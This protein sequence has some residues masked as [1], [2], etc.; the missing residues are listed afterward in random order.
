MVVVKPGAADVELDATT[1]TGEDATGLSGWS[2]KNYFYW[3]NSGTWTNESGS[4][5]ALRIIVNG[6][7]QVAADTTPPALDSAETSVD[8]TSIDLVFDEDLNSLYITTVTS[9]QYNVLADGSTVTVGDLFNHLEDDLT[10]LR[11][12]LQNLSPAITFGQ[13]V[14]VSYTDPTTGDDTSGALQDAAGNDVATFTTGSGGVPAVVNNVPDPAATITSIDFTS[15]PRRGENDDTY[16]IGDALEATVT[17]S[18]AVTVTG[19]PQFVLNVGGAP[20]KADYESGSGSTD[21]VFSYTV[22]E[23]DEATDG[24]AVEKDEIALN[25]GTIQA[26]MARMPR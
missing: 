8:G 1:A 24:V 26:G 20:R 4:D 7:E 14:T 17:F 9:T 25:G 15:V 13:V 23:G 12:E 22:V 10:R 11:I 5:R 2:I 3:N 18:A 19:T 16:R 6:Y 21:L